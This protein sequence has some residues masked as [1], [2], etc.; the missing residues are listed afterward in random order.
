MSIN[1]RYHYDEWHWV[2]ITKMKQT[3]RNSANLTIYFS[4]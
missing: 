3:N 1:M 4:F 2:L